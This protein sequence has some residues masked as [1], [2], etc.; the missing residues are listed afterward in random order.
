[1]Q[2]ERGLDGFDTSIKKL[3]E[4]RDLTIEKLSEEAS[5]PLNRLLEIKYNLTNPSREELLRIIPVLRKTPRAS[6]P[7]DQNK[8]K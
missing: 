1:M 6:F 2:T 8:K 4:N 7:G 3:R 5:I